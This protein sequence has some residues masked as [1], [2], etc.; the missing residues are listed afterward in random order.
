MTHYP[1][2]LLC[3]SSEDE[4][5]PSRAHEN[6]LLLRVSPPCRD[7]LQQIADTVQTCSTVNMQ[8]R[9]DLAGLVGL[10]MFTKY[11]RP[12][13][14]NA[15]IAAMKGWVHNLKA[16]RLRDNVLLAKLLASN[17][18]AQCLRSH[19]PKVFQTRSAHPF[20]TILAVLAER[21]R[22]SLHPRYSL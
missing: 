4:Q 18:V 22:I 9:D 6:T 1:T 10:V 11:D 5:T 20:G 3:A 19:I 8:T 21:S 12:A 17:V 15:A 7:H 2:I 13:S 14:S 16:I